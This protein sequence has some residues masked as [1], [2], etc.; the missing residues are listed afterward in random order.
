MRRRLRD[1]YAVGNLVDEPWPLDRDILTQSEGIRPA[2]KLFHTAKTQSRRAN[3]RNR[4][5]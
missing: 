5:R 1:F 4:S 3:T 2:K